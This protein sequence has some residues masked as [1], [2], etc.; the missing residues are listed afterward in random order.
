M[1]SRPAAGGGRWVDVAPERL[2]RWLAGFAERHGPVEVDGLVH[3][4]ADGAVAEL[5]P[6]FR[7]VTEELAPE[8]RVGVL[9]VRLGGYAAGVFEGSR[10]VSSKVGSRQVHGRSAAGGQSQQRFARRRDNQVTVA[11]ASAADNAVR[12]L[13]PERL[14]A[15]VTGGERTAVGAVLSDRRLEHLLPLRVDRLLDVPDPRHAV[16]ESSPALFRAVSIRLSA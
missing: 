10:L 9:L 4:G 6:P 14:D 1:S 3:R 15:L 7:P 2:E 12:V 8:L 5:V 13:A 16:L 11:Y